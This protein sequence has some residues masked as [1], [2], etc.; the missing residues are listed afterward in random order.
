M[1]GARVADTA[2]GGGEARATLSARISF[3]TDENRIVNESH[4]LWI[5]K[6]TKHLSN[7]NTFTSIDERNHEHAM[8][9]GFDDDQWTQWHNCCN[10]TATAGSNRT[11][12]VF[13]W[14]VRMPLVKGGTSNRWFESS[15]KWSTVVL[16]AGNWNLYNNKIKLHWR[17][18]PRIFISPYENVQNIFMEWIALRQH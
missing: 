12:T 15:I 9:E 1:N 17:E 18:S 14:K 16:L 6:G 13:S 5:L 8:G 3:G 7:G 11:G 10:G 4:V 2:G